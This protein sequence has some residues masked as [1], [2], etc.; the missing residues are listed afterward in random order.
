MKKTGKVLS[1]ILAAAMVMGLT[2]CSGG[3]QQSTTAATTAAATT[4][5]AE[6]TT[7][8]EAKQDSGTTAA[9]SDIKWPN[10]T[11]TVVVPAAAGSTL[12]LSARILTNYLQ[13]TTGSA[14]VVTNDTTGNGTVA[15]ENVR[16]AK[17][18]GST[19][20]YPQ[21]LF[22][23]SRGGVYDKE[24]WDNFDIIDMGS[25]A[26]E[27]Y[28]L[29][30]ASGK[31]YT[32][33]EEFVEYAKANPGKLVAG[34]QNGGQAHM[35]QA[36]LNKAAGIETQMVE[37]GSSADKITGIL[38]GYI[39]TAFVATGTGAGYVEAGDLIALMTVTPEKSTYNAEWPTSTELGFPEV[40]VLTKTA[41]FGPKGMDPALI[42][43]IND[44]LAGAVDDPTVI[45]QNEK[46]HVANQHVT[47]EEAVKILKDADE[48]IKIGYEAIK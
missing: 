29:V 46:L 10:G 22:I 25:D 38:G 40:Q 32:N 13:E 11:V 37:A 2:A 28:I 18:D 42:Q 9:A 8:A 3:G 17:P 35:L 23:Q 16:N 48:A 6:E 34:I 7:A 26:V 36:M 33:W 15:Y 27:S 12:D 44:T 20:M 1:M 24:P 39:D 5:A 41:W 45:E 43:K 19:I 31:E 14:F 21:N 30:A 4:A 47:P